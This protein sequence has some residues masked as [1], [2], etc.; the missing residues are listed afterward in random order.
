MPSYGQEVWI[1]SFEDS[2]HSAQAI[3]LMGLPDGDDLINWTDIL[4]IALDLKP[5]PILF[6]S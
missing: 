5:S 6:K 2:V 1:L 4:E 3:L